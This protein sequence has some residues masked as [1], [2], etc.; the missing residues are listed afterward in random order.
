MPVDEAG[1]VEFV[2]RFAHDLGAALHASTVVIG[3]KLGLYR[4]LADLGPTDAVALATATGCDCRLVQEWLD[5][6]YVSGYCRYSARTGTYW[7]SPEQAAV[8][9]DQASPALLVGSMALATSTAKDEEKIREAFRTGGGLAWDER[10]HDVF[11]GAE[12]L[13]KYG[14]GGLL[15]QWVPALDGVD[16]KLANGGAVAD[17]ACGHGTVSVLLAAAY[18]S[19]RVT[20]FEPHRASL[21]I[22]RKRA[23]ESG[24]ADRVQF[25]IATAQDFPGAGYDLVCLGNALG[26]I[27][28]PLGAARHIRAAL[29][30]DGTWLLV[31][32]MAGAGVDDNVDAV[33]RIFSA[34]SVTISTPGAQAQSGARALGNQVPEPELAALAS[35]AGF[36][37][38]RRVA[39]TTFNRI[40]EIRP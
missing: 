27:G 31:E 8:L 36:R 34:M 30:P 11:H 1:L 33:G 17:V 19:A 29:A 3:D 32:P 23:A 16:D 14:Y 38:F 37:R 4:A 12:R 35:E 15:T 40:F 6:Q 39:D 26:T 2:D 25:E 22:A 18:P 28:D 10:H 5:A 21:D 9:A 7:L 13:F 24:V 20:G